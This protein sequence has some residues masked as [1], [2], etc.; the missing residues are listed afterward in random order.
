MEKKTVIC[1]RVTKNNHVM[2]IVD[3]SNEPIYAGQLAGRVAPIKG[4]T[5]L[6]STH[7]YNDKEYTDIYW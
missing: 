1:S 4:D 7:T 3:G 6:V 2:L 5:V